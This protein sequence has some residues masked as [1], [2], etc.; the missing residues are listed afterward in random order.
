MR[1]PS[2]SCSYG[3]W[4]K[5]ASRGSGPPCRKAFRI[6]SSQF[7]D[8]AELCSLSPTHL[9]PRH[10]RATAVTALLPLCMVSIAAATKPLFG[11]FSIAILI[12]ICTDAA[13]QL[14]RPERNKLIVAAIGLLAIFVTAYA[15]YYSHLAVRSMPSYPVTELTERLSRATR[16]LNSNF[17]LP[18]RILVLTGLVLSPFLPRVRWLTLPL[19]VGFWLWANTASYDLRNALGLLLICAFIPLYAMARRFVT[20]RVA[21]GERQWHARDGVVAAGVAA[22]CVVLTLPLALSDEKLKQRFANE[23]MSKGLGI[24][25][26][27]HVEKLLVRGCKIFSNDGYITT[28]SAFKKFPQPDPVFP[29]CRTLERSDGATDRQTGRL[30]RYPVSARQHRSIHSEFRYGRSP[31]RLHMSR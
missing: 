6:G 23:Q 21:T 5:F 22:L 20:P 7:L 30:Y 19:G 11:M 27:Q 8:S 2:S 16:L 1:R 10:G 4:L 9:P 31:R 18:F 3:S 17:S 24:E 28:I 12:A 29:C 14:Q 25:I 15:I 26:N 13:K